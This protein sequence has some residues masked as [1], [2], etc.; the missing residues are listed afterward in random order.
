MLPLLCLF[1]ALALQ[2]D[3]VQCTRVLHVLEGEAA[4]DQFGWVSAPVP[5]QSGDGVQELLVG[6]PFHDSGGANAGRA[7]LYDGRTGLERF[8]FDGGQAGEQFG[9]SLRP[10]GDLDGDGVVDVVIGGRGTIGVAPGV[11]RVFSGASGAL[12]LTLRL[13]LADDAFGYAVEG[14]GDLDGDGTLDF[15]VGAPFEDTLGLNAGRVYVISGADGTTVLRSFFA[16]SARNNFGTALA[17]LGDV[18]GDGVAELAIGAA[19]AGVGRRGRVYVYDLVANAL[20]FAVDPEA[21]GAEFG[22]FFIA[23]AGLVTPDAVPDL[24]VGD[25]ADAGG[26]GKAYVFSGKTGLPWLVLAGSTGDGFGIGRGLGDVD[27]DGRDDLVLGSW[28]ASGGASGAGELEVF[29]GNDGRLLRRVTSLTAGE[30]LG[31]DAHGLGDVDGDG[32]PELVGTAATFDNAR[33]RVYVIAERPVALLGAGLAGS[34]A[35]VPTLTL[36]GCPRLGGALTLDT[37]AALGAA[38]GVLFVAPRRVDLALKGGMLVPD[39]RAL[40]FA[41][42]LGGAPGVAGAGTSSLAFVLPTDPSLLGVPFYSQ[43]LY[44]DPGAAQGIAFTPGLRTTLY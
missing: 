18:T 35:L 36:G 10:A 6:A 24:Y 19:N 12:L 32:V 42:V 28:T 11:A 14:M 21:S 22:Q 33:G 39:F 43:A 9:H 2:A 26:R 29:S 44:A 23:A 5:D 17:N 41:H 34:G 38:A 7:Y 20:D 13:G 4:G 3:F 31:F 8:H 27:G 15:A 37:G 1:S 40:R 30:N 25:F 16:E